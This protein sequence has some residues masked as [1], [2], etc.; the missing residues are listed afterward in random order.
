LAVMGCGHSCDRHRKTTTRTRLASRLEA[1]S[2]PLLGAERAEYGKELLIELAVRLA[3]EFGIGFFARYLATMRQSYVVHPGQV[4]D[5]S[6]YRLKVP[7]FL[8]LGR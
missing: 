6:G 8:L 1:C 7:F 4:P 5:L 3:S 2:T